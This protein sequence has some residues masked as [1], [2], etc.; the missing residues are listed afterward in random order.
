MGR[1]RIA[2]EAAAA[3]EQR[4]P[5]RLLS[6]H[7]VKQLGGGGQTVDGD[8]P[9][10][11]PLCVLAGTDEP[12]RGAGVLGKL[13]MTGHR[14]RA[15]HAAGDQRLRYLAMPEPAARRRNA[16]VERFP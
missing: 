13:K 15:R 16:L 10:V 8:G 14:I 12:I 5:Q 11:G 3:I 9:G 7:A 4:R 1:M 2:L 6:W